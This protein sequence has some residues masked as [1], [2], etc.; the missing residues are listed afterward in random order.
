MGTSLRKLG[1]EN[2]MQL[3][4]WL[5]GRTISCCVAVLLAAQACWGAGW[6]KQNSGATDDLKAVW[7]TGLNNGWAVGREG[8]I[9]TTDGGATWTKQTTFLAIGGDGRA[10]TWSGQIGMLHA[11]H[12]ANAKWGWAVGAGDKGGTVLRTPD[13]GAHWVVVEAPNDRGPKGELL[14]VHFPDPKNGWAVG[15]YGVIMATKDGGRTWTQQGNRTTNQTLTGVWFVDAMKGWAVGNSDAT[16]QQAGIGGILLQT[17]DG[18]AN[19]T[20]VANPGPGSG[21]DYT[22]VCFASPDLGWIGSGNDK[23]ARTTDGGKTWAAVKTAG[24]SGVEG[25]RFVDANLGWAVGNNGHVQCS[26]DG[27]ATW[28]LQAAPYGHYQAVC[29]VDAKNGWIVG[30]NGLILHTTTGGE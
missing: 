26:K 4:R 16:G 5:S 11:L 2:L 1:K 7:F 9:R 20:V 23:I 28:T 3:R 29:F 15:I 22:K 30:D 8:M 14:A 18:G 19:W 17:T 10:E 12:F 25:I 21:G 13:G 24:R 6:E 27:G